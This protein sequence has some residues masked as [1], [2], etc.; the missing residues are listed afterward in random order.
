MTW[1]SIGIEPDYVF[2]T[3]PERWLNKEQH[4]ASESIPGV[5]GSQMTFIGESPRS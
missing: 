2:C 5:W 3:R 1:R 4:P